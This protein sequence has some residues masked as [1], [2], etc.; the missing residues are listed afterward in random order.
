MLAWIVVLTAA[1]DPSPSATAP[2]AAK[3]TPKASAV[4]SVRVDVARPMPGSQ[5]DPNETKMKRPALPGA[6]NACPKD[7]A[8]IPGG[9]FFMGQTS[10]ES[11]PEDR[12]RF[13]TEIAPLCL[14]LTEVTVAAYADCAKAGKCEPAGTHRR[15]CN[16]R[17]E[18][19]GEH[20]V[21]CVTWAQA[22]AYCSFKDRR[23]PGEAEWEFAARG[24]SEYRTYSWG[25]EPPDGRTCWKHVGGSCPVKSFAPG[26][27]G[28][29]DMT[30]NVWEWVDDW[31]GQFPWPP[32]TSNAKGYRG[33][34]WSRR[35]EK[36]M[37]TRLRN[38]WSPK[39]EGSHLGFRC[40]L[41]PKDAACPFGRS[42]DGKRCQFGVHGVECPRGESFNGVRCARA[43]EPECPKGRVNKPGHG[44]VLA[45]DAKGAGPKL[46]ATPIARTRTPAFDADCQ[47]NKPGR[48]NAYRYSGGTHAGRNHAGAKDGCSNRDVGVGWNSACCP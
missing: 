21:N 5:G 43:G 27:F 24:G 2:S 20:P 39:K 23:L 3:A 33:G 15:F 42:A 26:A 17:F 4:A 18:D 16:A 30:G 13:E 34:S 47:Q 37:S 1:C 41:T 6:L 45:L 46:E 48:P 9:R 36:W 35:F 29:Y 8:H 19:R 25:N 40:A 38:R 11:A 44:C 7:M 10:P 31:F 32:E 28:L 22:D 12:P 14:D